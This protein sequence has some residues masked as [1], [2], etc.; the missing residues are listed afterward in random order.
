MFRILIAVLVIAAL[1]GLWLG[2]QG[3]SARRVAAA[4]ESSF[5]PYVDVTATPQ[6]AFENPA[7]SSSNGPVL[8]FVVSS[9]T[10]ACDPSWGGAYSLTSAADALD[11]DRRIAR[12]GQLGGKATIS[13]GGAANSELSI[14]CTDPVKLTA[15]YR[16][17]IDRYSAGV[18]DLD[19]EGS[20]ASS[21]AVSARRAIAIAALVRAEATAGH[22]VGVWLTLAVGPAG[23]TAEGL[24]V[25][26]AMLSAHV[27][28]A[29]VNAM[30]MNYGEPLPTGTSMADRGE[31]ALAALQHQVRS[32]YAA[33]GTDLSDAQ[34]WQQIGATAMIGQND[35]RDEEFGLSDAR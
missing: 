25:L 35:T 15:A 26:T 11:L 9:T 19:I 12:L 16:S 29:G 21:A 34:T 30:T 18:L 31:A 24:G 32:A 8:S 28:L 10:S 20:V 23:L 13:F 3:G 22:D 27:P 17:V 4:P 33:V 7:G 1:T 2:I 14:G 5:A 6:Y